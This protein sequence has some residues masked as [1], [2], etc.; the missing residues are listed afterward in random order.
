MI[1]LPLLLGFLLITWLSAMAMI[2]PINR[3]SSTL[4]APLRF[5][6]SDFLWLMILLQVSLGVVV[7]RVGTEQAEFF[8]ITLTF[9]VVATLLLWLFGVGILSRA[10]IRDPLR[11]AGFLLGILPGA[12]TILIGWPVP[13]IFLVDEWYLRRYDAN[14]PTSVTMLASI[15]VLVALVPAGFFVRI[16]SLWVVRGVDPEALRAQLSAASSPPPPKSPS[17][18]TWQV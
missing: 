3:L 14:G 15:A 7:N 8:V 9:L 17:G 18:T 11:R 13:I 5:Q 2:G 12:L 4:H 6:M 16:A 1:V 10:G